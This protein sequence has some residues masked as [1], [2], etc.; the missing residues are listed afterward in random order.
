[1]YRT[2]VDCHCLS[3]FGGSA[4]IVGARVGT[5]VRTLVLAR[6]AR[7][8]RGARGAR[9]A[10]AAQASRWWRRCEH[11]VARAIIRRRC[12]R[13][14][15]AGGAS[16]ART[17]RTRRP[18][19]PCTIWSPPS[20]VRKVRRTFCSPATGSPPL[21][22]V[23]ENGKLVSWNQRPFLRLSIVNVPCKFYFAG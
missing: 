2:C 4:L 8:A 1:M 21:G 16:A 17:S 23:S 9:A 5:F 15:G 12:G 19:A 3:H 20:S 11:M 14:A 18:A 22:S 6:G 13:E 7:A 10:R